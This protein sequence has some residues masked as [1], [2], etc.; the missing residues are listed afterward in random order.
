[1]ILPDGPAVG[2]SSE[3]PPRA[4]PGRAELN[5]IGVHS[6]LWQKSSCEEIV[7]FVLRPKATPRHDTDH[8]CNGS[9][10]RQITI[11]WPAEPNVHALWCIGWPDTLS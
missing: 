4:F 5:R 2:C 7:N 9:R 6:Q 11:R 10:T 3:T 8:G 1:M